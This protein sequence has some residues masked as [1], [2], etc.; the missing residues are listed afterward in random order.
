MTSEGK[1]N[2]KLVNTLYAYLNQPDNVQFKI[3]FQIS[4]EE[5]KS[6]DL[7]QFKEFNIDT[8]DD[9]LH[10]YDKYLTWIPTENQD[11]TSVYHHLCV[12]YFVLDLTPVNQYQT[13]IVPSGPWMWLSQWIIDYAVEVGKFQDSPESIT[14]ASLQSFRDSPKYRIDDYIE[15]SDGWKTFNEFFARKIKPELRPIDGPDDDLIIV[16]PADS[17]YDGEWDVDSDAFTSFK[18]VP[19]SISQLL[20]DTQ[21]GAL[22][23]GGKFCHSFLGPTDYHRQHAP[24]RGTVVEAKI[25]PGICYLEVA[26]EKDNAGN[27]KMVMKRGLA[28]LPR[29]QGSIIPTD[30]DLFA[31][32]VPG[33]QFLQARALI[34]I[35]NPTIGLV[36]VMP[37]G[38]AQVSSVVLSVKQG[39]I[40]EKGEEIS[41]FQFGGSDCVMVFQSTANVSFTTTLN[42]HFNFGQQ[43]AKANPKP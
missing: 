14:A 17:V 26:M 18:G 41:Y 35:D 25:I 15:P 43:V 33:Y 24:V 3:D 40:V 30:S 7:P 42:E 22:F 31:P 23:A 38:M 6:Y 4:F 10:H 34:L 11:S 9:Y 39:D 19:W 8:F 2:S 37:I 13:P 32:D 16:G 20:A 36:A 27:P 5:A 28:P 29:P 1:F 21:N 12:F